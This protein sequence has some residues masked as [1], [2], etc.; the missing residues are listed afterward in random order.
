MAHLRIVYIC[1]NWD[2]TAQQYVHRTRSTTTNY[3]P[4]TANTI[5][6]KFLYNSTNKND[7]P[8]E[9]QTIQNSV[10]TVVEWGGKQNFI[11]NC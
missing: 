4:K 1:P 10:R 6:D 7:A 9:E 2:H 3:V 8:S 11:L 5:I